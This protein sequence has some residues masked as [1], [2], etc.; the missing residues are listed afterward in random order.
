MMKNN[1]LELKDITKVFPGVKA[2]D[3]V[4]FSLKKGEVHALVGENGA[5]K[6]TLIKILTGVYQPN[7]GS[8]FVNSK[9]VSLFNPREAFAHGI[10]VVHQERNLVPTFT[11]AENIMIEQY[12]EKMTS[13]IN[14]KKINQDAQKYIDLVGLDLEPTKNV[15]ELGVGKKQLVEIA[16][17]LS[18]DAKILLLD[19]PTASIS[20][21][22]GEGL[23]DLVRKLKHEGVTFIFVSHKLEEVF[24][25]ADAVTVL[26][27]GKNVKGTGINDVY[28]PIKDLTRDQLITMM[29]GRT[30]EFKAF[31]D[32]DFSDKEVVLETK[33]LRSVDS[34]KPK[35][36][37]LHKGELLG[38]YGLVG[39]GRT[40]FA[41]ALI[42][43]DPP[44]EGEEFINGKKVVVKNIM[45]M[46]SK[47]K[48]YYLSENRKEEGLFLDHSIKVNISS[49]ILNKIKNRLG[50]LNLKKEQEVANKYKNELDI[51]TPSINQVVNNLSGGNQQK[52]SIAKGL[53]VEPDILII[54]EPTVGI[55]IKT[56]AEIHRLMHN[57]TNEGKS[58]ICITS[59]MQEIIQIADRIVVFKAGKIKGELK[60]TKVYGEM[61]KKIMKLIMD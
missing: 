56:K 55:D 14:Q 35:S 28:V 52:V 36:F 54:D 4:D 7:E 19:E 37:K 21:K 57:L 22:E 59:D 39:A 23:L 61:S 1:I 49:S 42:G 32:R 48:L 24:A 17:A 40:E 25:I 60:N 29:V 58:I 33:M 16:K 8:I 53:S 15:E 20:V 9:K 30:E 13:T 11:V 51:K 50:M 2:L 46:Q 5:G 41:R 26:R 27:D 43:Y 18:S 31:E 3:N 38:W 34:P 12:C 10:N 44:I 6:S 47:Y 45:Q